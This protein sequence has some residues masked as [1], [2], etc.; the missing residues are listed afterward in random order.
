MS[1]ELL[2]SIKPEHALNILNGKKTLELR[3]WIPK[4]Y[5]GWV[6]VYVSKSGSGLYGSRIG[7]ELQGQYHLFGKGNVSNGIILNGKVVFRFWLNEYET[8]YFNGYQ[9]DYRLLNNYDGKAFINAVIDYNNLCLTEE[10]IN[11]YGKGKLLYAWYIK[12]LEIF[13]KPKKLSEYGYI[14]D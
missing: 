4:D 12:Q 6:N 9:G 7:G 5:K 2:I 8:Y 11:D 14:Y 1:K 3:T 13:D 10:Q